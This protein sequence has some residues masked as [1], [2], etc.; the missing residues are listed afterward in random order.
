MPFPDLREWATAHNA[1]PVQDGLTQIPRLAPG[2]YRLCAVLPQKG[3]QCRA[4][5]LA[6][7]ATLRLELDL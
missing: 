2:P 1:P 7:G 6:A 4:G 3:E 5:T